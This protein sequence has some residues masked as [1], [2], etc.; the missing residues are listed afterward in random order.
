[1]GFLREFPQN[2]NSFFEGDRHGRTSRKSRFI[3]YPHHPQGNPRRW[4]GNRFDDNAPSAA[5]ATRRH[6][7]RLLQQRQLQPWVVVSA[8]HPR[9]RRPGRTSPVLREQAR[10]QQLLRSRLQGSEAVQEGGKDRSCSGASSAG[11]SSA[12]AATCSGTGTR[13]SGQNPLGSGSATASAGAVRAGTGVCAAASCAGTAAVSATSC[14]SGGTAGRKYD[15]VLA[16][17]FLE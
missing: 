7:R 4:S 14:S 15:G 12:S 13:G 9:P 1:M 3:L 17:P 10:R 2:D 6:R 5:R 11:G 16:E 8:V